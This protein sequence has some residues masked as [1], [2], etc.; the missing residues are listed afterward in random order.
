MLLL[1]WNTPFYHGERPF[2]GFVHTIKKKI[3]QGQK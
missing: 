2:S 3:L 1:L